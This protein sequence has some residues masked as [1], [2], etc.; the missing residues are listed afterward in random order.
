MT[1]MVDLKKSESRGTMGCHEMLW[2]VTGGKREVT[3][4][5]ER[6]SLLR[7]ATTGNVLHSYH[8]VEFLHCLCARSKTNPT[9]FRQC[10]TTRR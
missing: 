5:S 10:G 8:D 6:R 7:K 2:G 1:R 4:G 3:E 9:R